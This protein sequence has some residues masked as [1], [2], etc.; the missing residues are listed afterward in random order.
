MRVGYIFNHADIVGGGELSLLDLIEAIAVRGV[1]PVAVVPGAGEIK[2]RLAERGITVLEMA[3]PKF[4]LHSLLT[5]NKTLS[6]MAEC[7]KAANLDL[8]HVNGARCMLYAAP[9]GRKAGIPSLWHVRVLERDFIGDRLRAR[10]AAAI[11]ANSH[12]TAKAIRPYAP[13]RKPIHVIYNGFQVERIQAAPASDLQSFG[14]PPLPVILAAG[15]PDLNK[16]IDIFLKACALLHRQNVPFAPLVLGAPEEGK[17]RYTDSLRA[18]AKQLGLTHA[19]FLPWRPDAASLMKSCAVLALP[20]RQESF[21]RVILEAWACGLPV[22]AGQQ[23]GP[24]ELIEDG[25]SGL[26]VKPEAPAAFAD[27][28]RRILID[29]AL[30]RRL[31][32]GGGTKAKSFTMERHVGSILKCYQE[33]L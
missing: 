4:D 27:A 20:S 30:A 31:S 11:I 1:H 15:R 16:G 25:I 10:M 18:L 7:F 17:E 3:W 14:L 5:Y 32:D 23:G 2:R 19:V 28:F 26:L 13:A 22:V 21:G 8:L 24:A 9:A 29:P 6:R 33:L 12:A